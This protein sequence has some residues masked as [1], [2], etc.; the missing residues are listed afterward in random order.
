MSHDGKKKHN[1]TN[2]PASDGSPSW[3][4]DGTKIIFSSVRD[5]NNEIYVMDEDGRNVKRLT[6]N[7][8]SDSDPDWYDSEFARDVSP[9]EKQRTTW[10]GLKQHVKR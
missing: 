5:G 3:S 7:K 10:G 4:P 9:T 2:N 1:L 6:E 8:Q